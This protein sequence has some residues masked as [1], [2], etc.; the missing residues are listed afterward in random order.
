MTPGEDRVDD[1]ALDRELESLLSA[2]PSPAF[3]AR[4]RARVASETVSGAGAGWW[5][6]AAWPA[7]AAVVAGVVLVVAAFQLGHEP[8]ERQAQIVPPVHQ[9]NPPAAVADGHGGSPPVVPPVRSATD[10]RRT[11][12]HV[13]VEPPIQVA[14]DAVPSPRDPFSDV[15]V[16]AS[17]VR[18]VR[19]IAALLSPD[20]MSEAPPRP[21]APAE[22][23]ELVIAPITVA[24]I[25]L[26]PIEGEAE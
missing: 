16:S 11:R 5:S 21:S 13:S 25:Q 19:Q 10:D 7:A 8:A 26:R 6:W 15:L 9:S 23:S 22:I 4:I 3:Q 17:E 12:I 2:E 20:D 24:P 14:A 18:A 1:T